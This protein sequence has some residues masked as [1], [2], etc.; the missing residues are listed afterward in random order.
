MK[1]WLGV[2]G[3]GV[4]CMAMMMPPNLPALPRKRAAAADAGAGTVTLANICTRSRLGADAGIAIEAER[5]TGGAWTARAPA[6]TQVEG[7]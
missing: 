4:I 5:H 2:G 1:D 3:A 6:A 7:A